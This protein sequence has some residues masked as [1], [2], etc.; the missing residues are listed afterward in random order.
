MSFTPPFSLGGSGILAPIPQTLVPAKQPFGTIGLQRCCENGRSIVTDP[1][2]GQSVCSCQ[3]KTGSQTC[4]QRVPGLTESLY[5]SAS[6][7]MYSSPGFLG[8]EPS[9]FYRMTNHQTDCLKT[10]SVGSP[11]YF[12]NFLAANPYSSFYPSL[13][14]N[15]AARRKNATR[16]TTSA[17]KAWLFDHRKNPYPTKG[18][19]IMLAVITRMTLTQVS[20]WFA[21]ARRRLKKEK[22]IDWDSKDGDEDNECDTSEKEDNLTHGNEEN[23]SNQWY[24]SDEDEILKVSDISDAEEQSDT[25]YNQP[26]SDS[27]REASPNEQHQ[28]FTINKMETPGQNTDRE[29]SS[30][31]NTVSNRNSTTSRNNTRTQ[32]SPRNSVSAG[33]NRPRIWSISEIIGSTECPSPTPKMEASDVTS[34]KASKG[35]SNTNSPNNKKTLTSS[36]SVKNIENNENAKVDKS[37][38]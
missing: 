15:N 20:T 23:A 32:E 34:S 38:T 2:T 26:Q 29:N 5:G 37:I 27:L 35:T 11:F 30:S 18:E 31:I 7:H 1:S 10:P 28:T 33:N 13:D 36:K 14:L 19:K 21:N 6:N 22:R 24:S 16:E 9:A 17:L 3:M 4:M 12:E 8:A 25:A